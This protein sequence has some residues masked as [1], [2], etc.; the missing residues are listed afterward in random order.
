MVFDGN[1]LNFATWQTLT[2]V[3]ITFLD[4]LM[5]KVVTHSR[6]TCCQHLLHLPLFCSEAANQ[7]IERFS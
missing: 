7:Q 2:G 4:T 1:P 3:E 6:A 5:Y